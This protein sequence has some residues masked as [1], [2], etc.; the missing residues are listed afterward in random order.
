MIRGGFY[1][2]SEVPASFAFAAPDGAEG[3]DVDLTTIQILGVIFLATLIRASFGFGEA[4]VAVPLLAFF[5]PVEVATPLC[6]LVSITVASVVIVQDRRGI[7][8]GSA[9]RLVA[10]TLVGLPVGLWLLTTLPVR[11]VKVVLALVLVTF[12][13]YCLLSRRRLELRNDRL[14]WL[15]GFVAGVLGGAYAMNGP[16]L[17][18][19][20]SMR[21][22]SAEE[23]RATLQGYFLPASLAGMLG[24][25]WAGLWVEDVTWLYLASL[26]LILL[27]IVL[28]GLV[29]RR[30]SKG[31]FLTWVHLGLVALGVVLL[32]QSLRA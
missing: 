4:L 12:S 31:R 25:W 5:L 27:A 14:A 10:A 1:A 30:L 29:N 13:L 21:G 20:A 15:F 24:Y 6:A 18:V 32:A 7:H 9:W 23:F 16:P 19:Y 26:P 17:V 2:P 3:F 8:L 11:L 28:G 22:W